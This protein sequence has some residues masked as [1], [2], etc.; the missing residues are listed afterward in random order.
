MTSLK[1]GIENKEERKYSKRKWL[2]NFQELISGT[3]IN[4]IK[5]LCCIAIGNS[6]FNY[7]SE[8]N[9]HGKG[10]VKRGDQWV[11]QNYVAF[12][13][14]TLSIHHFVYKR[15]QVIYIIFWPRG[16]LTLFGSLP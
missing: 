14:Q 16:L 5:Y 4:I 7:L 3:I 8:F 9:S 10:R 2:R 6:M 15:S 13:A 1:K 12:A 11:T